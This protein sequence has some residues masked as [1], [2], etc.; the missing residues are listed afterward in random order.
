M[1]KKLK[2]VFLLILLAGA[3]E[4]MAQLSKVETV[5]MIL[6]DPDPNAEKD[7]RECKRLIDDALN[8]PKSGNSPK[9]W[10]YRAGVYF[11]ISRLKSDDPLYRETP[12][13]VKIASEA[14]IKC[15]ETDTKKDWTNEFNFYLV[16]VANVLFNTAVSM[17][18]NKSYDTAIDYYQ[19]TLKFL[20]LDSKGD[21]KTININ[22]D[23]VYQYCYYAAL[24]KGDNKL[25]KEYINKLIDNKFND[26]RIYSALAKVYLDEKDT[27]NAVKTLNTGRERF[28]ADQDLMNMELDI[29]LKQGK[30]DILL[31]K[32]EDAIAL[33]DQ[34]KI[35]Y[36]ARAAT[37]EKLNKADLAEK[38]YSKAVEI[39]PDYYDANFNLGVLNVNK[40]RPLIEQLQKTYKKADQEVLD[41]QIKDIY[42][43]AL[44]F[45]ERCLEIGVPGKDNR[46]EEY[47]LLE[48]MQRL[49]K[50]TDNVTKE[51][52]MKSR[53]EAALK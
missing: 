37:Y 29:Y 22:E 17:Y 48:N 2:H 45:F 4:S 33:D 7:L 5:R 11:E 13:A 49:Y 19:T 6:E 3:F 9:M 53:K 46:K 30:T 10:V 16:N 47:D 42:K 20:P 44:V 15:Y 52:E 26:P 43:R 41:Q 28:A 50:N 40:A 51:A 24:A 32:L 31:K 36:F 34:N 23:L 18:Q 35:Y 1:C 14:L 25:T 27:A 21:L 8:H 38:D 12:G 39:D